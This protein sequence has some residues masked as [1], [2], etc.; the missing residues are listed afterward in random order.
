MEL[1]P[2]I[3]DADFIVL[4]GNMRL[5]ALQELGFKEIPDN[6]VKQADKLTEDEKKQFIVKDNVGFGEWDW[7]DL[8]NNWNAD[9]LVDWGLDLP[10]NLSADDFEEEFT[11]NNDNEKEYR[12]ATFILHNNQFEAIENALKLIKDKQEEYDHFGNE[13]KNGNGIYTI[14]KEWEKLNK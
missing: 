9:D 14:V 13:N 11:L 12:Q 7:D 4:G 5:K 8:A 1:R 2:I 3:V 10:I 6:W